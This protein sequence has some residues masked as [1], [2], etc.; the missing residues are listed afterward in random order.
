MAEIEKSVPN[1]PNELKGIL[2]KTD[3]DYS[4]A[5]TLDS[6]R[7]LKDEKNISIDDIIDYLDRMTDTI[8]EYDSVYFDYYHQGDT[9]SNGL[10]FKKTFADGKMETFEIVSRKKKSL[11]L[12]TIY[13]E[14]GD[15][16]KKKSAET[17]LM[18]NPSADVQDAGRSNFNHTIPQTSKIVK[19]QNSDRYEVTELTEEEYRKNCEELVQM[20]SVANLIGTE[21]DGDLPLKEKI[22]ALF[23]SWGNVISTERFGDVA[24]TNSSIRSEF[25]HGT[26]R[27]KVISYAAIPSVLKNGVV[28]DI[29][30]K[31]FGNVERIIVAAPITIS[32]TP[33]FMGV[34]IQRAVNTNRLYLHD[35]VIRK[36]ASEY[37]SEHLNTTGSPDTENLFTTDVLEKAISVGYNIPQSSKIVKKQNS[38]RYEV[39]ELTEDDYHDIREKSEKFLT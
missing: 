13:I 35:V 34:M 26:T 37:H 14:K 17:M 32:N 29:Q 12:Q 20:D 22:I 2:F 24:L 33:Y 31:N 10:L 39:T 30:K 15:Y 7:H 25:R 23:D 36:E 3:K 5:V 38:D 4:I 21:L 1:L 28:I 9:K 27:E 11:N 19:R 6:I 16:K 18:D 8:V